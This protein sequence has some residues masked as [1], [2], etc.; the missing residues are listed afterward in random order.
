MGH[1]CT[2][3]ELRSHL[4]KWQTSQTGKPRPQQ[5]RVQP[6]P[7]L[8]LLTWRTR[9]DLVSQP[10]LAISSSLLP[11]DITIQGQEPTFFWPTN[12]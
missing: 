8:W 3:L 12:I 5:G 7:V 4:V 10:S 2:V 11:T 6:E 9:L 1:C